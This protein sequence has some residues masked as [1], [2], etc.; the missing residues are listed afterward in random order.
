MR[1]RPWVR[2]HPLDQSVPSTHL[3]LNGPPVPQRGPFS[4]VRIRSV[5]LACKSFVR[6]RSGLHLCEPGHRRWDRREGRPRLS[7]YAGG[8]RFHDPAHPKVRR[9][10][11]PK[12]PS[13]RSGRGHSVTTKEVCS[14]GLRD[15]APNLATVLASRQR[16]RP[17]VRIPLPPPTH[18][19]FHKGHR[20]SLPSG[21]PAFRLPTLVPPRALIYPP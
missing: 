2:Y 10:Q 8:P 15:Q 20:L 16:S 18:G 9:A 12:D 1:S 7:S 21:R 6:F 13:G 5:R 17:W 3:I 14:S 4:I 19:P 11:T